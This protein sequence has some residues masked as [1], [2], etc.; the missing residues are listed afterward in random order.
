MIA[1]A[2]FFA[3][4]GWLLGTC[5]NLSIKLADHPVRL[6]STPS[7]KDKSRLQEEDFLLVDG[8]GQVVGDPSRQASAELGVHQ[9][10]YARTSAGAVYHVHSIFNNLASHRWRSQGR[11]RFAGIEM[12]KGLAG[13]TLD[14]V[15]HLPIVDNSDNMDQLAANVAAGISPEVDAV[16]VYQHG[17]Y[18]WGRNPDEA[19]RHVEILEF[20]LEYVVRLES[21][22]TGC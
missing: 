20:L 1:S 3:Q 16:L 22:P 21:L 17:V 9:G 11:V 6:L 14:D 10:I 2:S 12:I 8:Q 7:G 4:R 15:V 18:S 5:G 13:K 19:R